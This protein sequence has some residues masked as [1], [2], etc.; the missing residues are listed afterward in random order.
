MRLCSP[1]GP[2]G[3]TTVFINSTFTV[4]FAPRCLI[5]CVRG[6]TSQR[7]RM[8]SGGPLSREILFP[9]TTRDT[10]HS[11]FESLHE[12]KTGTASNYLQSARS[13]CRISA[14]R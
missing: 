2:S 9:K 4:Q 6:V 5:G 8:N 11:N 14:D 12:K 3:A 7:G 13:R 10:R 1:V